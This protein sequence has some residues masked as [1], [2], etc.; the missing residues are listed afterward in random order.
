MPDSDILSCTKNAHCWNHD[1]NI[2]IHKD[3]SIL[4][5]W[6]PFSQHNLYL[7]QFLIENLISGYYSNKTVH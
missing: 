7:L 4:T 2:L 3:G 1:I 5:C 6:V